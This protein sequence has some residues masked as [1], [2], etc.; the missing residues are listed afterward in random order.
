MPRR[1]WQRLLRLLGLAAALAALLSVA[2]LADLQPAWQ[3]ALTNVFF[4]RSPEASEWIAI[5]GRDSR[6]RPGRPVRAGDAGRRAARRRAGP[7][8]RRRASRGGRGAAR[9]GP[10]AGADRLRRAGRVAARSGGGIGRRGP[11]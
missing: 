4:G 7:C 10:A 8:G 1:E 3:A 5:V 2:Y 6:D 11:R 9:S